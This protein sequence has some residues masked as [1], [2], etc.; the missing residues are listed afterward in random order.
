MQSRDKISKSAWTLLQVSKDTC[1]ANLA[2]A[3]KTG[4][5]KIEATQVEKL[6]AL[7]NASIDEGYYRGHKSFLKIVENCLS[8]P[9]EQASSK[10][11]SKK[12]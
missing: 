4:Q 9:Q 10:A 2:T 12:K 8:E 5:L 1:G 7:V 3:I 11:V 6:F